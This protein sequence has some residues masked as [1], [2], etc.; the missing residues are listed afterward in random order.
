M[1]AVTQIRQPDT[2]GRAYYER[3]RLEGKT[4]NE[5][6]RC[7]KRRLSDL[8]YR[9]L[10]P[11]RSQNQAG[12]SPTIAPRHAAYICL[13]NQALEIGRDTTCRHHTGFV[14]LDWNNGRLIG[15]EVLD[16]DRR[17]HTHPLDEAG[18]HHQPIRKRPR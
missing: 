17:L 5:A 18:R 8:V 10:S 14:A 6:L 12:G 1:M 7:L 13:T 2:A 3:K 11:T 4:P 9:Q 15:I 16:A